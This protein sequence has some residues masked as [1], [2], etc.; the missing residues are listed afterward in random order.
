MNKNF[1]RKY[2]ILNIQYTNAFKECTQCI[3]NV[4][5]FSNYFKECIELY[6]FNI[7]IFLIMYIMLKYQCF[8]VYDISLFKKKKK[9]KYIMLNIQCTHLSKELNV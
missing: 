5:I 7:P 6:I 1:Q 8:V 2:T 9:K 3:F 4:Y